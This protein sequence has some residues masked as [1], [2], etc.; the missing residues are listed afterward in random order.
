MKHQVVMICT[1]SLL[2]LS[3][4]LHQETRT[5]QEELAKEVAKLLELK[6]D[7]KK[8]LC[9]SYTLTHSV[10]V[11]DGYSTEDIRAWAKELKT[12]RCECAQG[13][14]GR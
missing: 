14:Q 12:G 1:C 7:V 3:L 4:V 10:F 9:D 5:T 8:H 11:G 2:Y 13:G 6:D